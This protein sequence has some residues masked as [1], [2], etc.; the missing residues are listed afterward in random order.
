MKIRNFIGCVFVLSMGFQTESFCQNTC[1]SRLDISVRLNIYYSFEVKRDYNFRVI[2]TTPAFSLEYNKHNFYIGPQYSYIFQRIPIADEIYENNSYGINL[3]YRYY[4]KELV[5][6]LRIFGQFNYSIYRIKY[7]EYQK[8]TPF[9]TKKQKF[10][11]ENTISFG[12]DFI[13]FK[14]IHIY[15]GIGLGSFDGFF[16]LFKSSN[17]NTYVGFEYKF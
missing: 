11:I 6:K 17:L 15:S 12:M 4:S 2:H 13:P 16:L 8:G 5:N 3:G 1:V 9:S 14:H 7:T 10:I